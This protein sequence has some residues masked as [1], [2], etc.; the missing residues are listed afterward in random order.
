MFAD[1]D[2]RTFLAHNALSARYRSLFDLDRLHV[3]AVHNTWGIAI[4]LFVELVDGGNTLQVSDGVGYDHEGTP[5]ELKTT[6]PLEPRNVGDYD[7][8]LTECGVVARASA[9]PDRCAGSLVLAS[10]R[11]VA[12][13]ADALRWIDL[14]LR[15]RLVRPRFSAFLRVGSLE[16]KA[17]TSKVLVLTSPARFRRT[18]LYF[19][20]VIDLDPAIEKPPPTGLWTG[21]ATARAQGVGGPRHGPF[22]TICGATK[23]SF[24]VLFTRWFATDHPFV[25]INWVGVIP[26]RPVPDDP[27]QTYPIPDPVI[28]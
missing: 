26:P 23:D 6:V 19:C 9:A 4:G 25:R 17:T 22:F 11:A 16:V 21:A 12:T 13:G 24:N 8:V 5:I 2:E 27:C 20:N 3:R 7:I 1:F 18:P 10:A 28:G 14:R 15:D